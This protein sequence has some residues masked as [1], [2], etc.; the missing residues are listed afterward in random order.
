M[1][2]LNLFKTKDSIHLRKISSK[3]D[4]DQKEYEGYLIE[5]SE[6]EARRI[7]ASLKDKK[8]LGVIC[9]RGKD[10]AFNRRAIETLKIDYLILSNI[11]TRKKF[12]YQ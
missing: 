3:N 4:L 2:D 9:L 8:F 6:S 1:K 11:H 12:F 7:I 10:D 5:S